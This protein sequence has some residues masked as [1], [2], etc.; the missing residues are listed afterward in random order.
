MV[1]LTSVVMET[2][3]NAF[4]C[5]F[6]SLFMFAFFYGFYHLTVIPFTG[7]AKSK[8][9]TIETAVMGALSFFFFI[10]PFTIVLVILT[11]IAVVAYFVF[12]GFIFIFSEARKYFTVHVELVDAPV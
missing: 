7:P 12:K 8:I 9:G 2:A 6:V 3:I 5:L 4:V 1:N 11:A 10:Y